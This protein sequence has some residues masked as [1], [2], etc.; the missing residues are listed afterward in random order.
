MR[1]VS[2]LFGAGRLRVVRLAMPPLH[3]ARN[4]H[5]RP[6]KV[7]RKNQAPV[8]REML[9]VKLPRPV[10]AKLKNGLTVLIMEDRRAP[11]VN[12]AALYRRCRRAV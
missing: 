11:F 1:S 3:G 10:E 6:S 9:R 12:I 7:E 8:S 4:R 2:V 5:I